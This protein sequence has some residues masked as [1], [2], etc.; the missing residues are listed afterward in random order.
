MK[1]IEET[2]QGRSGMMKATNMGKK[3]VQIK[4]VD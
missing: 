3:W 4:R 2:I 1:I